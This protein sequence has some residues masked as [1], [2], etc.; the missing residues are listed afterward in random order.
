MKI[1]HI[2]GQ[3]IRHIN[4]AAVKFRCRTG[5]TAFGTEIIPQLTVMVEF[6]LHF[7]TAA[8]AET[9][10]PDLPG[11]LFFVH[12]FTDA[13]SGVRIVIVHGEKGGQ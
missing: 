12:L 9:A 8:F 13:V 2:K 3:T 4:M 6:V 10:F 7:F 11:I 1:A 5:K